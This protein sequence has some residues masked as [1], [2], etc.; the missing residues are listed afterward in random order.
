MT[1]DL[2]PSRPPNDTIQTGWDPRWKLAAAAIGLAT[3]ASL[4]TL[5]VAGG[6]C[7]VLLATCALVGSRRRQLLARLSGFAAFF[8]LAALILPAASLLTEP[9]ERWPAF[10]IR[11]IAFVSVLLARAISMTLVVLLVTSTTPPGRLAA[12][13]HA[14][15]LPGFLVRLVSLAHRYVF[16]LSDEFRRLRVALQTRGFQPRGNSRRWQVA[17]HVLGAL[18]VRGH[19]R[20]ERVA[21][22]MRCRGFDGRFHSLDRFHSTPLDSALFLG[23]TLVSAGAVVVDHLLRSTTPP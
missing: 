15:H 9:V 11:D 13:A 12:A 20:G 16:L 6:A 14:L 7:A 3:L 17:A 19:D 18:V 23:W 22:A 10:L 21:Q 1:L 5:P 4:A 8:A 2:Q